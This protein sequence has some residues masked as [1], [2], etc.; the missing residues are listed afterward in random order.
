MCLPH[1]VYLCFFNF[2][3]QHQ[4]LQHTALTDWPFQQLQTQVLCVAQTDDLCTMPWIRRL[5]TSLK[6]QRPGFVLRSVHARSV[7]ENVEQTGFSPSTVG[8]PPVSNISPMVH[9]SSSCMFFLEEGLTGEDW[10]LSTKQC[11]F[12]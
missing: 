3:S 12:T 9:S 2:H 11:S 8:F 5:V 7:V 4:L 1:S 10:E 6:L